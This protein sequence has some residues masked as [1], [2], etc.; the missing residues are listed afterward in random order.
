VFCSRYYLRGAKA[1]WTSLNCYG[2]HM[3]KR[4]VN[5]IYTREMYFERFWCCHK[6]V[7]IFASLV[8][9]TFALNWPEI[10][11]AEE[12]VGSPLAAPFLV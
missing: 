3:T 4:E 10:L 5:K 2:R 9:P 11:V 1:I 8:Y 6:A 7:D 12:G